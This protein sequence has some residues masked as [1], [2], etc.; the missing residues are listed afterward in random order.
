MNTL[1]FLL[2]SEEESLFITLGKIC[3]AFTRLSLV[4][5]LALKE[6]RKGSLLD[7]KRASLFHCNKTQL[8]CAL[9]AS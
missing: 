2:F 9:F 5:L 6:N 3:V 4:A 8:F 1:S 7:L